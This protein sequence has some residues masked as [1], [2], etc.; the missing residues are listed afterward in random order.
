MQ[1]SPVG[2][3]SFPFPQPIKKFGKAMTFV[4][5]FFN[6]IYPQFP[7]NSIPLDL[8]NYYD[9]REKIKGDMG[10]YN[11]APSAFAQDI[12]A[13]IAQAEQIRKTTEQFW[14][15]RDVQPVVPAP[16]AP[17]FEEAPAAPVPSRRSKKDRNVALPK[18]AWRISKLWALAIGL[19][20]VAA[21]VAISR[22]H[23]KAYFIK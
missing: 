18:T 19:F 16:A 2:S 7:K 5:Q 15:N 13:F 4:A 14:N 1:V 6:E 3:P 9:N 11:E 8:Q 12:K 21:V 10:T 22:L 23:L 20:V 17:V